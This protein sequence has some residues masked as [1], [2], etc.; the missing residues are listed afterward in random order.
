MT[1]KRI[2]LPA[3]VFQ[4]GVSPDEWQVEAIDD[5]RDGG[6]YVTTFTGP[7][8]RARAHDY[9]LVS[10]DDELGAETE[11]SPSG[12][13]GPNLRYSAI[14]RAGFGTLGDDVPIW[15]RAALARACR[16]GA[17]LRGGWRSA[18]K[19]GIWL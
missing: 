5:A 13:V 17:G 19:P 12:R 18:L 14:G 15:R 7:N 3:M 2:N 6:C 11:R 1:I 4:V 9:Q 16:K 10:A 8:V